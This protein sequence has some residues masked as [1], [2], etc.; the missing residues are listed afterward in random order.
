MFLM[1]A[2][3]LVFVLFKTELSTPVVQILS[4]LIFIP[5]FLK[6]GVIST[7]MIVCSNQDVS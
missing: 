4:S 7:D 3:A 2:T 5:S 1:M 6:Y